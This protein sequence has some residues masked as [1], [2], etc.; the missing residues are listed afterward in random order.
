[1]KISEIVREM[2]PPRYTTSQ[3]A[4]QVGRHEDTLKRW[5]DDGTFQP[6][7]EATF[8]STR[9]WLYTKEDLEAMRKIARDMKPGRKSVPA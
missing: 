9:V 2:N 5:R 4:E 7:E 8:G 1:M 3:A 6:S